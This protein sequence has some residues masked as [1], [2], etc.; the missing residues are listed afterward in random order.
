MHFYLFHLKNASA[1]RSFV[2][3]Q[4]AACPGRGEPSRPQAGHAEPG[5]LVFGALGWEN[6]FPRGAVVFFPFVSPVV[7][8]YFF[9]FI[10]LFCLN[11]VFHFFSVFPFFPLSCGIRRR[12]KPAGTGD[13]GV[14]GTRFGGIRFQKGPFSSE[15][16]TTEAGGIPQTGAI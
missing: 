5:G 1:K 16:K 13:P 11:C 14:S 4:A 10:F 9:Y 2:W 3:G 12:R 15:C 7:F 8:L 6:L